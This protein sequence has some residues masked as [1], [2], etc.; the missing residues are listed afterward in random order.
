MG[1]ADV[2]GAFPNNYTDDRIILDVW[3]GFYSGSWQDD[4]GS[5]AK[6]NAS[7][8]VSGPFYV[9]ATDRS[10]DYPHR[11]WEQMYE[12]DLANFTGAATD[13]ALIERV[14]G[15]ELA[16]WGDAAQVDSGNVWM[17]LTPNL[18]AVAESWWSPRSATSGRSATDA[19]PRL[20]L[21]RC[22]VGA[23]GVPA[24]TIYSFG[25]VWAPFG[26]MCPYEEFAFPALP[27]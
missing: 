2:D 10:S 23:R 16:A 20:E 27:L 11:T 12:T 5:L 15:G 4:V 13:P 9:S 1:W 7:I 3:S 22:R 24:N 17:T 14:L 8:I 6:K 26:G 18:F 25:S 21:H 19:Q